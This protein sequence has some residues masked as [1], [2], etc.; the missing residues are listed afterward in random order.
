M[1]ARMRLYN[2]CQNGGRDRGWQCLSANLKAQI[3]SRRLDAANPAEVMPS[4]QGAL[5]SCPSW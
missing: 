3:G 5:S 4:G 2:E 1:A